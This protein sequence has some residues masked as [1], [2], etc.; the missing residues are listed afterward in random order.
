MIPTTHHAPL[1][2]P[3]PPAQVACR[4][5]GCIIDPVIGWCGVCSWTDDPEYAQV[6]DTTFDGVRPSST[7]CREGHH[8]RCD[9]RWARSERCGCLCHDDAAFD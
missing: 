8:D 4:K 6:E 1:Y 9:G 2:T 3:R 7:L 5:C